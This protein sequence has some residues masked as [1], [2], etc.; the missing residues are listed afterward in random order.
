MNKMKKFASIAT[1]VLMTACM[2]APMTMSLTSSAATTYNLVANSL[3]DENKATIKTAMSN[4][5]ATDAEIAKYISDNWNTLILDSET[6]SFLQGKEKTAFVTV[7]ETPDPVVIVNDGTTTEQANKIK[8]NNAIGSDHTYKA[9]N[10]FKGT[11]TGTGDNKTITGATWGSDAIKEAVVGITALGLNTNSTA[12]DAMTAIKNQDGK[13]LGKLLGDALKNVTA[14]ATATDGEIDISTSGSGWYL[15]IDDA[16]ASLTN[17]DK[18]TAYSAYILGTVDAAKGAEINAKSDVPTVQKK[19]KENQEANYTSLEAAAYETDKSYND[20]ADYS[21]GKDVSFKLYG[22]LPDDYADYETYYYKFT[23]SLDSNFDKPT[24]LTIK[25]GSDTLTATFASNAWTVKKG[26]DV[27]DTCVVAYATDDNGFTVTFADLK[28]AFPSADKDTVITV[29]YTAKLNGTA[30]VGKPGQNNKVNLEYSNN[31]NKAGEGSKGKTPDDKVRVYTYGFELEK[32]FA[33]DGSASDISDEEL[34]LWKSGGDDAIQFVL[35]DGTGS[36][37]SNIY[38][39]N[40]SD[41]DK[42]NGWDY[43]VAKNSDSS[44]TTVIELFDK[45]NGGEKNKLGVKIKGLDEGTYYL[46]EINA[47]DGYNKVT[48]VPVTITANTGNTQDWGMTED[49]LTEFKYKVGEDTEVT[50][51]GNNVNGIAEGKV[52]NKKGS[53]LPSTGGIGTTLFYVG[54]G[55][56]VAVAGVFLI[57]KKR[58]SKKED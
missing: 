6:Y 21:I 14:S 48:D 38:V 8:I 37:A 46:T 55:A 4:D 12:D 53:S 49:T 44:A 20:I 39:V 51:T 25:A 30:V 15:I 22:T 10:I 29:E 5:S 58:M 43:V 54:G 34:A 24:T 27:V 50:Q 52:V 16:S 9:Y 23:D 31:P 36:G 26:E 17:V 41:A 7:T 35:K 28:A 18:K 19:V 57:T 1:A 56:M 3:T 40:A 47:P 42:A 2:A 11:V 45:T 13:A 32:T 33:A